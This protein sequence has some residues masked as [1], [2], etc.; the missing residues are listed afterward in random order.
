MANLLNAK[1][2]FGNKN[3]W[4]TLKIMRS[5]SLVAPPFLLPMVCSV[6]FFVLCISPNFILHLSYFSSIEALY[7]GLEGYNHELILIKMLWLDCML[8]ITMYIHTCI[9]C[10][11]C[12]SYCCNSAVKSLKNLKLKLLFNTYICQTCQ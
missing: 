4:S 8:F 1:Y 5:C 10:T 11:L 6:K 7:N 9:M 3:L 2:F 12:T